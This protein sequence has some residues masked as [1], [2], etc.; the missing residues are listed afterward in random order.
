MLAETIAACVPWFVLSAGRRSREMKKGII[1]MPKPFPSTLASKRQ[2]YFPLTGAWKS[3]SPVTHQPVCG[4]AGQ[5]EL[6][7]WARTFIEF[8]MLRKR[9]LQHTIKIL[10]DTLSEL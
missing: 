10:N 9:A 3:G 4:C 2:Y 1:I 7:R 6:D 5:K 8:R